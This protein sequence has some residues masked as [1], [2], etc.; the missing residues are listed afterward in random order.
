M[1]AFCYGILSVSISCSIDEMIV[2]K[3]GECARVERKWYSFL[4]H[5]LLILYE[6]V[7]VWPKYSTLQQASYMVSMAIFPTFAC[8]FKGEKT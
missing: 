1:T 2:E 6:W 3:E 4:F 5:D 8:A 7:G